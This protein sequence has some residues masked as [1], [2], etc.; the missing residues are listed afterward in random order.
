MYHPETHL[1][2]EKNG[3]CP[4]I[5]EEKCCWCSAKLGEEHNLD[6]VCRTRTVKMEVIIQYVYTVPE[7][8]TEEDINQFYNHGSWCA[9]NVLDA[10]DKM[11]CLCDYSKFK[12]VGEATEQ[13]E[14]KWGFK[15]D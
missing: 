2:T 13:D 12:Y 5:K 9:I 3:R 6:C 8:W 10:F 4:A 14:I 7:A 1:V 11:N 15:N